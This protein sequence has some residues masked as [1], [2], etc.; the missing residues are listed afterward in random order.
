KDR[1]GDV[2]R[3]TSSIDF[4]APADLDE[5]LHAPGAFDAVKAAL[6]TWGMA[7]PNLDVTVRPGDVTAPIMNLATL[8]VIDHDWPY[9]PGVM[10]VTILKIDYENNRIVDADI[11]FNAAQNRFAVLGADSK[12]GGDFVDVQN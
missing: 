2:V 10:A 8:S 9:D 5:Q 6:K 4:V 11:Y 12:R 3:W 1:D 7:M